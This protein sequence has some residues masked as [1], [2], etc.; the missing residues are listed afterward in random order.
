MPL[1]PSQRNALESQ[2]NTRAASSS[3]LH[4]PAAVDRISAS[5]PSHRHLLDGVAL[6]SPPPRPDR[7]S[8]ATPTFELSPAAYSGSLP[9]SLGSS[10]SMGGGKRSRGEW[11]DL[12][13]IDPALSGI[14]GG[15][16]SLGSSLGMQYTGSSSLPNHSGTPFS[17]STQGGSNG[18]GDQDQYASRSYSNGN[19]LSNP[20]PGSMGYP[21]SLFGNVPLSDGAL[22]QSWNSEEVNISGED[23]ARVRLSLILIMFR[24]LISRH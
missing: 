7:P 21:G 24:L 22:S 1:M 14:G 15:S 5:G 17:S 23:Y 10:W 13:F 19:G 16:G 2:N 11:N 18:Y 9:P 3:T 20:S 8:A 6:N 12:S 4:N